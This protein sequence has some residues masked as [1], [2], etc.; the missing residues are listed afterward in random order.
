MM[1][2]IQSRFP[3]V[4]DWFGLYIVRISHVP[5]FSEWLHGH[6]CPVIEDDP[7]PTDWAYLWEYERF[8]QEKGAIS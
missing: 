4:K 6:V 2:K 1:S 7:D 3:E 8:I 5:G